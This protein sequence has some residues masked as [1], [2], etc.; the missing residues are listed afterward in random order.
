MDKEAVYFSVGGFLNKN[1]APYFQRAPNQP[2]E[3]SCSL[4]SHLSL[5]F[6]F[7]I[8]SF[9]FQTHSILAG[10]T[11]ILQWDSKP[12]KGTGL[13]EPVVS[14]FPAVGK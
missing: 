2:L 14:H 12:L 6:L 4:F 11:Y 3:H 9:S 10:F 5:F 1:K 8:I 13:Q 7:I